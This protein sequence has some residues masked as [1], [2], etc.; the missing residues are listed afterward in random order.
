VS[1]GV[2]GSD[3]KQPAVITTLTPA[4]KQE[5]ESRISTL[6]VFDVVLDDAVLTKRSTLYVK[7][8]TGN[9]HRDI[10][11]IAEIFEL[12]IKG[13]DCILT[14]KSSNRAVKLENVKCRQL[15]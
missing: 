9:Y 11:G 1:C 4:A 15:N 2:I 10:R 14:H 12:S 7:E 5:L 13:D 6:L 8:R 3:G